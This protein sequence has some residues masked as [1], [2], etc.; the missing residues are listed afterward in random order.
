MIRI[1]TDIDFIEEEYI[2]IH[3]VD[4]Y[5]DYLV[6]GTINYKDERVRDILFNIDGITEIIDNSI[7]RNH[8]GLLMSDK[9]STGTKLALCVFDAI[10]NNKKIMVNLNAAGNNVL[11]RIYK[12]L[13]ND[14]IVCYTGRVDL[15][16]ES[17]LNYSVNGIIVKNRLG[18]KDMLIR[19]VLGYNGL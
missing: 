12:Y 16:Y 17:N 15:N 4:K 7:F 11:E 8:I 18:F 1:F 13:D 10:D 6:S 2:R 3:N 14:N 19:E 9:F 5:F